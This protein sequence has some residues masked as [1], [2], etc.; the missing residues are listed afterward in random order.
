MC[1]GFPRK[2]NIPWLRS[3]EKIS[4]KQMHKLDKLKKTDM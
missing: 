2:K 1:R 3:P 4:V